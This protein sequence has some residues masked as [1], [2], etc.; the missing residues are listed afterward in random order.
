[1]LCMKF[2]YK[3]NQDKP[4][5]RFWKNK[6]KSDGL[7]NTCIDCKDAWG[8]TLVCSD[9]SKE[10]RLNHRNIRVRVSHRCPDCVFKFASE[11]IIKQNKSRTRPSILSTRGYTYLRDTKEKHGYILAHRKVLGDHLGRK[12]ERGEIVHHIDGDPTN[13]DINN[14]FLTNDSGHRLAHNSLQDLAFALF[15]EGKVR[16]NY[17]S[18][19]YEL[20]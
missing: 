10:F 14:L 18:G 19:R 12:L 9:C 7:Q 3:C 1:M 5:N 11:R 15:Q 13:N 20:I 17:E 16:F 8:K 6:T 2:C 4:L